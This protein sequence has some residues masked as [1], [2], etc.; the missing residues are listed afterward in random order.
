VGHK[1]ERPA[2][3]PV[4]LEQEAGAVRGPGPLAGGVAAADEGAEVD[5][6]RPPGDR[7]DDLL[8]RRPWLEDEPRVGDEADVFRD[9]LRREQLHRGALPGE[10]RRHGAQVRE[11][12]GLV[13]RIRLEAPDGRS[14]DHE[15]L[16]LPEEPAVLGEDGVRP[17]VVEAVVVAAERERD[18][19]GPGVTREGGE[20]VIHRR[21]QAERPPDLP[22]QPG[23]R[24]LGRPS[25]VHEADAGIVDPVGAVG[26]LPVARDDDPGAGVDREGAR[27]R[28]RPRAPRGDPQGPGRPRPPAP[29]PPIRPLQDGRPRDLRDVPPAPARVPG[30]APPPGMNARPVGVVGLIR[31]GTTSRVGVSRLARKRSEAASPRVAGADGGGD[32]G[33]VAYQSV[34]LVRL[35]K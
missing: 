28:D 16:P 27:A 34:W 24:E 29:P 22:P 2:G 14:P 19:T 35:M 30:V 23:G 8:R 32:L 6:H 13:L 20:L 15:G 31:L 17:P 9:A 5:P 33:Q 7:A 10:D 12:D 18:P 25:E 26:P 11:D 21:G 1:E 4:G 3:A